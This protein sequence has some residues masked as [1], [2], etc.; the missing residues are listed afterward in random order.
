L[1]LQGTARQQ[2]L[3][4][5]AASLAIKMASLG[6]NL[7]ITVLLARLLAPSGYGVYSLALA[8]ITL[9]A[10]PIQ[11]GLP[12]LVLREVATSAARQDWGLVRGL[13]RWV[14]R[15]IVTSS[16]AVAGVAIGIAWPFKARLEAGVFSTMLFAVPL[17][18][19]ASL[20]SVRQNVLMG[21]KRVVVAQIPELLFMPLMYLICITLASLFVPHPVSPQTAMAAYVACYCM[22]FILG[23]VLL[24]SALPAAA[25]SVESS[26]PVKGWMK[27]ILTLSLVSGLS[28]IGS[29]VIIPIMG[30]LASDETIGL[31]RVAASGAAMATVVGATIGSIVSPYIATYY[32]QRDFAKLQLLATYS[33]WACLVPACIVLVAYST[34]G[35]TLLRLIFGPQF[36]GAFG[37]LVVLTVGQVINCATGIVH[38]LLIMTGH[39]HD[40]LRGSILGVV[41]NVVLAFALVPKFGLMGAAAATCAAVAAENALLYFTVRA[42]LHIGSSILSVGRLRTA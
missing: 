23:S 20:I 15:V 11:L 9:L 6:A 26:T 42:R 14:H 2:L 19:V 13:I 30:F 38:S 7:T 4:G 28:V 5:G 35:A 33:A 32:S 34:A 29:Q 40:T 36:V 18:A 37:A 12:T 16:V 41:V 27:S 25:V 8:I 22:A 10:I 1:P 17:L 39:E 24:S 3:S 21:M 31:Y